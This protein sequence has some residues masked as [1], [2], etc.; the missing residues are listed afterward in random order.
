MFG[1][2]RWHGTTRRL[3]YD[4]NARGTYA[5]ILPIGSVPPAPYRS[6]GSRSMILSGTS[7]FPAMQATPIPRVSHEPMGYTPSV[8][9][10][11]RPVPGL[12]QQ[13]PALTP[14]EPFGPRSN[15]SAVVNGQ[16]SNTAILQRL[17]PV[18]HAGQAARAPSSLPQL[19]PLHGP[20]VNISI[21]SGRAA[22]AIGGLPQT[23]SSQRP[24]HPQDVYP[25]YP[26][27]ERL[28]SPVHGYTP[29]LENAGRR[30]RSPYMSGSTLLAAQS[31]P[32]NEH[33]YDIGQTAYL[34][35]PFSRISLQSHGADHA[36]G[37]PQYT[38]PYHDT[39]PGYPQ[40]IAHCAGY[41]DVPAIDPT[42][43]PGEEESRL[44]DTMDDSIAP[45]EA[46]DAF[47]EHEELDHR[48]H[49]QAHSAPSYYLTSLCRLEDTDPGFEWDFTGFLPLL[50][51]NPRNC[52][53][54]MSHEYP[55][56][57]QDQR[58]A[59]VRLSLDCDHLK[60]LA[61]ALAAE[62]E[63]TVDELDGDW[64]TELY[65]Q[66]MEGIYVCGGEGGLG[67]QGGDGG[68]EDWLSW[69]CDRFCS[70]ALASRDRF[71]WASQNT[72]SDIHPALRPALGQAGSSNWADEARGRRPNRDS[73]TLP[74]GQGLPQPQGRSESLLRTP[75]IGS[76][77]GSHA[78]PS[79]Q[80]DPPPLSLGPAA[81]GS[82]GSRPSRQ[83]N[84]A[85]AFGADPPDSAQSGRGISAVR[86][87]MPWPEEER[88]FEPHPLHDVNDWEPEP[89]QPDGT[90]LLQLRAARADP[91][92]V[93]PATPRA[94]PLRPFSTRPGP[95]EPRNPQSST[96]GMRHVRDARRG[97]YLEPY[98]P[99]QPSGARAQVRRGH[100]EL[101]GDPRTNET[102]QE[103]AS[104]MIS[105]YPSTDAPQRQALWNVAVQSW[106][107]IQ[108][109]SL[110]QGTMAFAEEFI[111]GFDEDWDL[112]DMDLDDLYQ[113][114]Q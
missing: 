48:A 71:N 114:G 90:A 43:L 79:R 26:G 107:Y 66:Y 31:A 2:E 40:S 27:G 12:R 52:V 4:P 80:W 106:Q 68:V 29:A 41:A 25:D 86:D 72:P 67:G 88:G 97:E 51:E 14:R 94:A 58:I 22:Q 77:F 93:V 85:G 101:P 17:E 24:S 112:D 57:D 56:A 45:R 9:L 44:L 99:I 100:G 10:P 82:R 61:M 69:L 38:A 105:Q 60:E 96:S 3:V 37:Q 89:Y 46:G 49:G 19:G 54:R 18:Q 21:P 20:P 7:S 64:D 15:S 13:T 50:D 70:A 65:Y 32:C 28:P 63:Q 8:Q 55:R 76:A 73:P 104:R 81:L 34:E 111:A 5:S 83:A 1:I 75:R 62:P 87:P 74:A 98:P 6:Q 95:M 30:R 110:D 42:Y 11:A 108:H 78:A 103:W 102:L 109:W 113:A 53:D 16:E 91:L 33:I 84:S 92:P 47:D 59:I 35:P 23:W 39:S 36:P